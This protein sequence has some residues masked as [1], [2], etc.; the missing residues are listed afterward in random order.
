[1]LKRS[2]WLKPKVIEKKCISCGICLEVCP[3]SVLDFAN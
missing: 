2:L 3:T 1:M